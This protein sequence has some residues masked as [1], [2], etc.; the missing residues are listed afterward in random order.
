M[1]YEMRKQAMAWMETD[2]PKDTMED[3]MA[4]GNYGWDSPF[5]IVEIKIVEISLYLT[6]FG[7]L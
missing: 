2:Y 3:K 5:K 4:A 1:V 7:F 6:Y